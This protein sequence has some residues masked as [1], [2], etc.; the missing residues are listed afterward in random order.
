MRFDQL[1]KG[2]GWSKT[3]FYLNLKRKTNGLVT[4]NDEDNAVDD[5][6]GRMQKILQLY[7]SAEQMAFNWFIHI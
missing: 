5:D 1:S 6:N 7:S 2:N 3:I 4:V